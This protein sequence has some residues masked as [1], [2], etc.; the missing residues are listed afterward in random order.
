MTALTARCV[1]GRATVR[2]PSAPDF[3]MHC[4]CS[5]CTRLGARWGYYPPDELVVDETMLDSFVREDAAN[6]C[7]RVYRC[8]TCGC[9]THYR[10]IRDIGRSFSGVNAQLFEPDAIAGVEVRVADRRSV[11]I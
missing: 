1:C 3:I 9:A 6:P 10:L 4:N 8:A 5:L 11:P 7:V 2:V